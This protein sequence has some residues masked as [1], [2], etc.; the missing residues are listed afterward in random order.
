MRVE[1]AHEEL[2]ASDQ[3]DV[4]L[5]NDDLEKACSEAFRLVSGFLNKR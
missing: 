1:K 4:I 5:V 2:N 3:F